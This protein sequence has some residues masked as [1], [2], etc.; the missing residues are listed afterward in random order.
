MKFYHFAPPS[1]LQTLMRKNKVGS[2]PTLCPTENLIGY[3]ILTL[4][5]QYQH[6]L[7]WRLI[8]QDP[9][10]DRGS[11][12]DRVGD[13]GNFEYLKLGF[14]EKE[15]GNNQFTLSILT[16]RER[17]RFLKDEEIPQGASCVFTMPKDWERKQ[18]RILTGGIISLVMDDLVTVFQN[19]LMQ[20]I[21]PK[22]LH[23]AELYPD[24]ESKLEASR[25]IHDSAR[26]CLRGYQKRLDRVLKDTHNYIINLMNADTLADFRREEVFVLAL[27]TITNLL[28][29]LVDFYR[30]NQAPTDLEETIVNEVLAL[31]KDRLKY[32]YL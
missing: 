13:S 14:V 10:E 32:S 8:Q 26:V 12:F 15:G 9:L 21:N 29:S 23:N 28:S 7:A 16:K 25:N 30:Q 24:G 5:C 22:S 17:D 11:T 20:V 31:S 4:Y 3:G 6:P 1:V 2:I 18:N 19:N 27:K